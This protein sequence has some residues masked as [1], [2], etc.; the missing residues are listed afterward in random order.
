MAENPMLQFKKGLRASLP[1]AISAGTI[2]VTTDER[3]M[4]VDV[5]DTQ[6]IRLGDFIEYATMAEFQAAGHYSTTA[7][8]YI[9]EGHKLLKYSSGSG[10]TITFVH[11]NGLDSVNNAVSELSGQVNTNKTDIATLKVDV[12][13]A[14]GDATQALADAAAAQTQADKGVADAATAQA[15]ADAAYTLADGADTQAKTNKTDIATLTGR[16]NTLEADYA[17]KEYVDSEVDT[18]EGLISAADAKGAQG[19]ADAATAKSVADGAASQAATNKTDIATLGSTKADKS[20]VEALDTAYKAADTALGE[21][22][23]GVV[24]SVNALNTAVGITTDGSDAPA[25][26]LKA[27]VAALESDNTT[28][29]SNIATLTSDK[30]DKTALT[31]VQNTLQGNINT[32]STNLGTTNTTLNNLK[33]TVEDSVT[34][35]AATKAIADQNKTDIATLSSTKLNIADFNTE[36]ETLNGLISAAQTQADKGVENAATAQTKAN[37][38]YA[39]AETAN[40][41]ANTNKTDIATLGSNKLDK[42]EFETAKAGLEGDIADVAADV[43]I[44]QAQADKGVADAAAAQSVADGAA[45]QAATNKTDIANLQSDKLNVSDFNTEKATLN[46]AIA[47]AKK[48]GDDAQSDVDDLDAI[49]KHETTG[50]AATKAIADQNKTDIANLK[51]DKLNVSDFNTEKAGLVTLIEAADAKGAQGIADAATAQAKADS[52]YTLA[53]IANTQA[54]TNKNDIATI[55]ADYATTEYVDGEIED[56]D[57]ELRAHIA[58]QFKAADSM[59]FMGETDSLAHLKDGTKLVENPVQAG[60]VYV[61]TEVDSFSTEGKSYAIG[62][63]F[64][65]AEDDN[66]EDWIHVPSGYVASHENSLIGADNKITLKS[67]LGSS[68]S[69]I[70][71]KAAE[72]SSIVAS[73]ADNALTIGMMWGS[74]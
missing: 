40:S 48:A 42:S 49:V 74:F 12:L 19:I 46:E 16:V 26:S 60:D 56:L 65:A 13:A 31:E 7:L 41:Q 69:N 64:I 3:A 22:I 63:L 66:N 72:G 38:A 36:K 27:K 39:L 6:R 17:T 58:A 21:R 11:L 57:T 25:G 35:L 61:L 54:N 29:K 73:V 14:Q 37:D 45:S 23:D 71:V 34:G 9:A 2:Y 15:R 30:A 5:S 62:D 47:A 67:Y 43:V 32:V 68:L 20:T 51:T 53:D 28:N 8:Y 33:N 50:L 18:L 52:A 55:F 24:T 1:S 4:Y 44:A 59:R 10:D 70:E